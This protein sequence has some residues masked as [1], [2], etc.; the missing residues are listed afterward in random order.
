MKILLL[1][2]KFPYPQK[3][4]ESIAIHTLSLA[5]SEL[6]CEVSLLAMNTSKH[7]FNGNGYPAEAA[8]FR[9][10]RTVAIDNSIRPWA[11]FRNLFSGES[12]HI[13]RFVSDEFARVL[14]DMLQ[15]DTYDV[16]QLE[17]LYLAP[18]IPTIR[19]HSDAIVSMRAHNVEHEI[20]ERIAG[21]TSNGLKRWYL[22]H[23][24][25][26]L[27]RY[28][29]Q[30]L[31]QYDLLLP[32]TQRD[33]RQFRNMG[34]KGLS[35]VTPIG[36]SKLEI[37]KP[38]EVSPR[39]SISFIGSLDWM[40][41]VE[42]LNWFIDEVWPSL[43]SAYPQLELHIAGRNTPKCLLQLNKPGIVVHGEVPDSAA[44]IQQHPIMVVPL[45]TGSGM[46]AKIL[47]G[48]ALGKTVLTTSIGLEGIH[49][50]HRTEVMIANT[51][52]QFLESLHYLLNHPNRLQQISQKAR[53]LVQEKYNS[54]GIAKR[55]LAAYTNHF[56][57]IV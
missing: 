51:P 55:V 35:V 54:K 27:K 1:C 25:A 42:G 47:E 44:F 31:E 40:P 30:V 22:H 33:Q 12:Y 57:E 4:G 16:V 56:A 10:I 5:L 52:D 7:Y 28:E 34:F 48:M 13:A 37:P 41:N 6:G 26:K 24:T 19:K 9:T 18:Y 39:Q 21:N 36:V 15:T 45:L 3:D 20:W 29:Q 32:I 2:K 11:A 8:H 23:L 38:K 14:T 17:T 43:Q 49:A 53:A 50:N 46:R